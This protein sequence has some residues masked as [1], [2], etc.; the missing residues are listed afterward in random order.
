MFDK[1]GEFDSAEEL[2]KAAA[3]LKAE[4]DEKSLVELAEENGLDKE[5]AEDY[6]DGVVDELATP[7]S[8]AMGKIKVEC[9]ELKP[10]EIMEDWVTYIKMQCAENQEVARQV[11]KKDK[12]IRM[13]IAKLLGWSFKNAYS[14]PDDISSAAGIKGAN[15]KLGIPGMGQAKKIIDEYYKE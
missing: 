2:N 6:M 12:S 8:A 10:K 15:V 5:D 13:C 14:I 4:G 7:L 9:E 1:F 3:G 11:R